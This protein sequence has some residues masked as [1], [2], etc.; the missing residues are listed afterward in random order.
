M[1]D[2]NA[3]YVSVAADDELDE[4]EAAE[5]AR[6]KR[7]AE[8]KARRQAMQQV[9]AL[10]ILIYQS[11]GMYITPNPDLFVRARRGRKVGSTSRE[12]SLGSGL[13]CVSMVRAW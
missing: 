4:E 9:G 1:T 8:Q 11:L 7:E 5:T 13:I 12:S 6:R 10:L 2:L 3:N